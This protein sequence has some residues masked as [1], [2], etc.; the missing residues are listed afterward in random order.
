MKPMKS[1]YLALGLLFVATTWSCS[2][3]SE[4]AGDGGRV[5]VNTNAVRNFDAI[6]DRYV[7]VQEGQHKH[8][9][10]TMRFR[11]IDLRDAISIAIRNTTATVC[12]NGFGE[13]LYRDRLGDRGLESCPIDT[14]ERVSSRAHAK[15][16]V[17]ARTEAARNPF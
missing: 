10:F 14:I 4:V 7:Y 8:Y 13:I 15:E 2:T 11:C 5:C 9:L 1:G 12:S 17:K 6:S 16:L 3:T